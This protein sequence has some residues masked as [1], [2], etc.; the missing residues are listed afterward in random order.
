MKRIYK[1]EAI[2]DNTIWYALYKKRLLWGWKY[3]SR[4]VYKTDAMKAANELA[5]QPTIIESK[6]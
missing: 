5:E 1:V 6:K 2:C 4:F 3:I